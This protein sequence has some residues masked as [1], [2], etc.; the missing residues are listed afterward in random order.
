LT[1]LGK[2]EWFLD[3]FQSYWKNIFHT[4]QTMGN[5]FDIIFK[6]STKKWTINDFSQKIFS[7][8]NILSETILCQNK[9][10]L[11]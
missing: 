7:T 6:V 4:N 10:S 9:C 3:G 8:E 5:I 1:L 11:N 2:F